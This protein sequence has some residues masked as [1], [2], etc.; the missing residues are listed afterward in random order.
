MD[1]EKIVTLPPFT[2]GVLGT[3]GVLK[4]NI[5]YVEIAYFQFGLTSGKIYN[6]HEAFVIRKNLQRA[7]GRR[8]LVAFRRLHFPTLIFYTF[9]NVP[10]G[11]VISWNGVVISWNGVTISWNGV[12]TSWPEV[13]RFVFF[14]F[15]VVD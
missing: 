10:Y 1:T 14:W 11:V 15:G 2:A 6:A 7:R 13:Y 5:R 9:S 8:C 12:A 3:T 4:F